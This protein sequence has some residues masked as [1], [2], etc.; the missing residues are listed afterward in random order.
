[1]TDVV[2]R[3]DHLESGENAGDPIEATTVDL[4]VKMAA[5]QHRRQ[6]RIASFAPAEDVAEFIDLDA[7]ARIT[8]PV[9]EEVAHSAIIVRQR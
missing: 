2:Q 8:T 6:R 9:D 4:G 3:T 5:D 7:Q 1:M